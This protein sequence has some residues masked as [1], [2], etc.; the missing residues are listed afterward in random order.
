MNRLPPLA[1]ACLLI[2]GPCAAVEHPA[3]GPQIVHVGAVAPDVLMLTIQSGVHVQGRNLP[4]VA[5]A[6]DVVVEVKKDDPKSEG[7]Q[8]PIVRDGKTLNSFCL[9]LQR[10]GR[11]VGHL[12][13][14]RTTLMLPAQTTGVRLDA[15]AAGAPASFSIQ[16][17]GDAAY[18]QATAPTAV[19]RKCKPNGPVGGMG[20]ALR[21]PFIHH[22][23][24]KLPAPLQEGAVYTI[25]LAGLNTRQEQVAYTHAARRTRSDAVHVTQVG[26]APDD[27]CKRAYLS[28]WLGHDAAGQEHDVEYTAGT[29][30]LV[31]A[32]TGAVVHSGPVERTKKKGDIDVF[33]GTDK[34]PDLDLC[35]SAV[36]RMDFSAFSKPGE[37]CVSIPGI[38]RSAP[39]RIAADVWEQ[40]FRAALHSILTQRSGI[41]LKAPYSQWNRP[42]N[43]REEDGTQFY[44][45]TIDDDAGQEGERGTNMLEL[46]KR[47]KLERVHGVWGAHED[48]GDWDALTHH[49]DV[50]FTLCELYDMFPQYFA[51]IRI[52]LPDDEAKSPVPH[53][54]AE[55]V[56][57]LDGF[58]RLQLPDGGVRSGY[59]DPWGQGENF[60][61]LTS[62]QATCVVVYAP[63]A[64]SSYM[65]AATAARAA[66]VL[67]KIA[68]VKAAS[69]RASALKAWEW[70]E[71]NLP[72]KPHWGHR[73]SRQKAIVELFWLT[74]E[75]RFSA[76]FKKDSIYLI[77]EP[78]LLFAYL[79]APE[80][81]VPAEYQ[82][83][84]LEILTTWADQ[85]IARGGS[86]GFNI[87][88]GKGLHAPMN[89]WDASQSLLST[90]GGGKGINMARLAY[91]TKDPKHVAAVV[92]SCNYSF[93]GNPMNL[94]YMAG[95]GWNSL[96]FPLKVDRRGGQLAPGQPRGYIPFGLQVDIA[97]WAK[98]M[99]NGVWLPKE[100]IMFPESKAW[101]FQER[102]LDWAHDPN[103][104]ECVLDVNQLT[105]VYN[106]GFL[107]A[108]QAL[109][110]KW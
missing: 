19:Y 46:L 4:Y 33:R 29:F 80:G 63:S 28:I 8:H 104:N 107:M 68:P 73:T 40:P 37:Y 41:E 43:F 93:G 71:K 57:M 83:K 65:F 91:V 58:Q 98:N 18:K 42:R 60:G 101:P 13:P 22:I 105:A 27:A 72:A 61:N 67:E 109:R 53:I 95:V 86:N 106:T 70:A 48:A 45:L 14:D 50:P 3:D 17:A 25:S 11:D 10:E 21:W 54:L 100:E 20:T 16:S 23:S 88:F 24:L 99:I 66:R 9:V 38:G 103:M 102:Y 35:R 7:F 5:E 51:A 94:S 49:L 47:G 55:A 39:I 77:T 89:S 15:A 2:I 62:W 92:Q 90:P 110:G 76:E 78:G 64:Y 34:C 69:Y 75:A 79:R 1:L 85:E 30:E 12:S 31:E 52:P 82:K 87:I 74:R 32:A 36:Y 6:G 44:Q 81:L 59:G 56:W 97:W 96:Q 108:W 84:S 26:Y